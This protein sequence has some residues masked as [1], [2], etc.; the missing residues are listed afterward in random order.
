MNR[1]FAQKQPMAV[2]LASISGISFA[3]SK[4]A[5]EIS[6]RLPGSQLVVP[7]LNKLKGREDVATVA[8]GF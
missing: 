2:G 4:S 1:P 7:V 3:E 5:L 8:A 6:P